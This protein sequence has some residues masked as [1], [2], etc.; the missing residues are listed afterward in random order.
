M[1]S[2]WC[3]VRGISQKR[4]ISAVLYP[5]FFIKKRLKWQP[6][7][8]VTAQHRWNW[9]NEIN[10]C[11]RETLRSGFRKR[12]DRWHGVQWWT[13]SKFRWFVETAESVGAYRSSS[14]SEFLLKQAVLARKLTDFFAQRDH[15][16]LATMDRML[17]WRRYWRWILLL[18]VE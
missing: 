2:R 15:T 18:G 16:W 11:A 9:W 17:R 4:L 12:H 13:I 10:C 1:T 14:S 6:L 8:H 7:C 3:R 5:S